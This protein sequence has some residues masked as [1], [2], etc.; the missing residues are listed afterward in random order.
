LTFDDMSLM[1]HHRVANLR[2]LFPHISPDLNEILMRFSAGS[3]EPYRKLEALL[4]D[5]RS[6]YPRQLVGSG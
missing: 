2:K 3:A 6:L 4:A 1:F 5:L